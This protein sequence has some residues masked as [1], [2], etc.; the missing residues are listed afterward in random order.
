MIQHPPIGAILIALAALPGCMPASD[1]PAP[2]G[3]L[4][5]PYRPPPPVAR[6]PAGQA[7]PPRATPTT[8]TTDAFF[9]PPPP[10]RFATPDL[11]T[12]WPRAAFDIVATRH[13]RWVVA[14]EDIVGLAP[15]G[16]WVAIDGAGGLFRGDR[17]GRL[18]PAPT[19][20]P[21]TVTRTFADGSTLIACTPPLDRARF[22]L[23]AGATWGS[24]SFQCGQQGAR[25]IAGAGSLTFALMGE[26]LRV[27]P[28]PSGAASVRSSPVAGP[29]AIGAMLDHV[30]IVGR[31]ALAFSDDAGA[32]FVHRPR[33][34]ALVRVRDVAFVGKGTILLA[35]DAAT[36]GY[37][38]M[39]SDDAGRTWQGI[40]LPRRLDQLAALAVD[41]DGGVM[42]VPVEAFDGAVYSAD[43]GRTFEALPPSALAE[44]AAV[45]TPGGFMMGSAR[46]ALVGYGVHAPRL[47]LQVPL[48]AVAFTHPRVA[49]GI[50]QTSGLYRS[51]DGGHTWQSVAAGQGVRFWDVAR[52]TDHALMVVG[53]GVLW[54]SDDA[55]A[56]WDQRP[57]PSSCQARWVRF[58]A[59]GRRGTVGCADG[60]LLETTDGG[61][62]W[63]VGAPPPV[64]LRPVAWLNGERWA[65]G[66]D[67][68][69]YSDLSGAFA[70]IHSP[71]PA[72]VDLV[73]G[74]DG[75]SLLDRSGQR[76]V[77][78]DPAT[79]WRAQTTQPGPHAPRGAID[80]L[81]LADGAA[82]IRTDAQVVRVSGR[83]A[84]QPLA[85]A[86][87]G[88]CL[89]GDGGLML[90]D[91][92][93]TSLLQAR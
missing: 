62:D 33:P 71:L 77:L 63:R 80:H 10:H 40:A 72:P 83:A 61:H 90:L 28:L 18:K 50:G 69:L 92:H 39:R 16:D 68:G 21:Q 56:R 91:A 6:V 93:R 31:E 85:P 45:A 73:A 60:G 55:G 46:G 15:T 17:F 26:S 59:D 29:E 86:A 8:P 52:I 88:L 23:D 42:A 70:A 53:D 3:I 2:H 43:G 5:P 89:T 25:T 81:P 13:T 12:A 32:R 19:R 34:R 67:G 24:L 36:D 57:L 20:L 1:G 49:V 78:D 30:L 66:V 64:A 65:L 74:P 11:P 47:G 75:L 27:G 35:G 79:G 22:S 82:L 87:D 4:P 7:E 9:E 14:S 44:G 48:H 54:R 41:G 76:A 37:A 38:L 58:D 84:P 51:L